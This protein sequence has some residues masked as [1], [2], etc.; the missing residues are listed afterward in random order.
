MQFRTVFHC[1]VYLMS[2]LWLLT[3]N[4]F[5]TKPILPMNGPTNI[6]VM[7][8]TPALWTQPTK[9]NKTR[10]LKL[11]TIKS[12]LITS[13]NPKCT[14]FNVHMSKVHPAAIN[15]SR[16][17]LR[18]HKIEIWSPWLWSFIAPCT[19]NCLVCESYFAVDC[20]E[21]VVDDHMRH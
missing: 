15:R 8:L 19:I 7:F 5:L 21:C 10:V 6:C 11:Y 17:Q 1:V 18:W 20:L 16:P 14:I 9:Y 13:N 2:L 12:H 4:D 3:W